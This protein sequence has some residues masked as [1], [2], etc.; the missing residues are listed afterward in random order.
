MLSTPKES[1]IKVICWL[2][3]FFAMI[4]GL[5]LNNLL[6]VQNNL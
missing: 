6:V 2:F 3:Q 1:R 4:L 5:M